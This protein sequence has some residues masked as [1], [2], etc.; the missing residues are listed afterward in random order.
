MIL[1]GK[2]PPL[3]HGLNRKPKNLKK[4]NPYSCQYVMLPSC[5]RNV[6]VLLQLLNSCV[7]LF[8]VKSHTSED[9][10]VL[11]VFERKTNYSPAQKKLEIRT[12]K[13]IQDKLQETDL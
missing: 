10:N 7:I 13:E 5:Y 1:T 6:Q 9:I 2:F 8:P 12:N 11:R 4:F 3:R